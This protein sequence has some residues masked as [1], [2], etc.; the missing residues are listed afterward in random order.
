MA[1]TFQKYSFWP[2]IFCL[3][4]HNNTPFRDR[5]IQKLLKALDSSRL[6]HRRSQEFGLQGP[7]RIAAPLAPRSGHQR[8][9]GEGYGEAVCP[10]AADWGVW[11]ASLALPA[12]SG[13]DTQRKQSFCAFSA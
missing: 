1:P 5:K 8:R 9:R 4:V 12:E 10:S 11:G 2:S 13:A 7:I 6:S 3:R